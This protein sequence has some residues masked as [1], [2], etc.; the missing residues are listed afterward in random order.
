M[1]FIL[2]GIRD[3]YNS[4]N[5]I[6]FCLPLISVRLHSNKISGLFFSFFYQFTCSYGLVIFTK[7]YITSLH[8]SLH[9]IKNLQ[10]ILLAPLSAIY[11]LIIAVRN[12]CYDIGIFKSTSFDIPIIS[13]GN[14]AV[15]GS[16]KTPMVEYL[17][18]ELQEEYTIATLSRGYGRKT[19]GFRW[20]ETNNSFTE[21]GDEPL[22]IKS[23][24][25]HIA[26]AVCEDRVTGVKRILL[27]RPGI[28]L[29]LLDDAFQHRAIKPSIQLLLSTYSKPFYTDWLMP[30]G[31][32]RESRKGAARADAL[33][34]TRCPKNCDKRNWSS[35]PIFYSRIEYQQASI[36]GN[37][38]GFS[39]LADNSI[40]ESHLKRSYTLI[41]FQKYSDHYSFTQKDIDLLLDKASEATLVCTEKDWIKI[42]ELKGSE[43]IKHVT[44]SNVIEGETDFI[45]W[46]KIN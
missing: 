36:V 17:I 24:F 27:E 14:L 13:I 25:E 10:T 31:R 3:C 46:L 42:K 1:I 4:N 2:N 35:K 45:T 40:F 26:V 43:H 23:K 33:I 41:G 28:N 39:A 7:K 16:G 8:L 22:Q 29:I 44:I 34:F 30:S 5:D 9:P 15:G 11:W 32:L 38:F 20:V 37:I 18:R 19:K 12:W 21:T 6:L